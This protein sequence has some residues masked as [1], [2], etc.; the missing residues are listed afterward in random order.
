MYINFLVIIDRLLKSRYKISYNYYKG[1]VNK[2]I[3]EMKRVILKRI[4]IFFK[5]IFSMF[6][7]GEESFKKIV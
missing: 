1:E 6:Y 2:M 4:K 7:E 3:L 5:M